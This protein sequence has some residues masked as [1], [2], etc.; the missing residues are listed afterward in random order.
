MRLEGCYSMGAAEDDRAPTEER[1]WLRSSDFCST[2]P[3]SI[4][5]IRLPSIR[6]LSTQNTN[7]LLSERGRPRPPPSIRTTLTGGTN[8]LLSDTVR[9]ARNSLTDQHRPGALV[10]EDFGEQGIAIGAADDV[11]AVN[12]ATQQGRDALKFWDHA[13]SRRSRLNQLVSFVCCHA[14][15]LGRG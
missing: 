10:C 1:S 7:A 3:S 6:S 13:A 5:F 4:S 14:R 9:Q 2:T 15:Q 11:C 8:A 12:A